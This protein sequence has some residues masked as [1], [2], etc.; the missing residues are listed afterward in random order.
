MKIKSLLALTA[1]LA[2]IALSG[3][4]T[5]FTAHVARFQQLPV[6]QGQT[7]A[8]VPVNQADRGGLEFATYANDVAAHL[9]KVGYRPAADG[10]PADMVVQLGYGV[11]HGQQKVTTTP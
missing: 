7:F 8:V 9:V 11:D 3:C 4:A 10:T 5:N 6:P 2:L 1:P